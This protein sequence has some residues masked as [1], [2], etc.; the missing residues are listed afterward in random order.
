MQR[1]LLLIAPLLATA[2]GWIFRRR[3]FAWA[4]QVRPAQVQV[5]VA[6]GLHIPMRDGVRLTADHYS[7]G[8]DAA[9]PVI[10]IRSP[11]GRNPS[12][13][14]FGIIMAFCA[15]RF[16]ERGYQVVVQDVRGRGD[17]EGVY[18]PYFNEADDGHD[19]LNWLTA[20]PWCDGRV[21]MWGSSYLGIVQWRV[22]D[23]PAVAALVPG[24]SASNLYP[25]V[26][27]DGAFDLGLMM[28]WVATLRLLDET[29]SLPRQITGSVALE[30]EVARAFQH[31]PIAEADSALRGGEVDYFRQ[32]M[33][34]ALH[35]PN[36]SDALQAVDMHNVNA[37][38]HL[39][40]GWYDFFLRGVLSDYAALK[41]AGKSPHLTIGPW[42]HFS[43][44]FMLAPMLGVA[45]DWFDQHLLHTTN[46]SAAP[47]N[48]FVMGENVWRA[49]PEYPPPSVPHPIYLGAGGTLTQASAAADPDHFT[50]DP[51][52]PTPVYGG[53]QFSAFAGPVD[54]RALESRG[55]VLTYTGPHLTAPLEVIG[56]VRAELYVKS[57]RPY[58]DFFVRI[59][60]VYPDGRSINVCDGLTRV[61][62]E[63]STPLPDGSLC[64]EIDLWATAYR[65][66]PGHRM[67]VIV[68]SG[69]HPRWSRHTGGENPLVDT[70]LYP[71][72]QTIFHDG[73]HPS[74]VILPLV[75][76]A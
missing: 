51:A 37:P 66:K 5:K 27:P 46:S 25:I 56:A 59:C 23:H 3:L 18:Q 12:A 36:F 62:P 42:H 68:G 31:L 2:A 45:I 70:E 24:A 54:N 34:E 35:D 28:R 63:S 33:H 8:S 72:D 48:V 20:Q 44:L 50:Y 52:D 6:W 76:L 15:Q 69:A 17:A 47:V 16:A 13:G 4:L 7:P 65:F 53:T 11:Y 57:S 60:D 29:Q 1:R 49:Y 14:M 64:V 41:A 75:A 10:L 26:F 71:A 30:R 73:E 40:G 67:R 74:A 9:L 58:T 61:T 55:D 43:D 21:A 32:W 39:V 19:T 38:V 22:A